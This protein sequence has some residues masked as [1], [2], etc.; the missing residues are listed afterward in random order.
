M[1]VQVRVRRPFSG[2]PARGRPAQNG[3][4]LEGTR[5]RHG[6]AAPAS[7]TS[8]GGSSPP[9]ATRG[10]SAFRGGSGAGGRCAGRCTTWPP[11]AR[12]P[13]SSSM[14]WP[15]SHRGRCPARPCRP[16]RPVLRRVRRC[17]ARRWWG[18]PIWGGGPTRCS[19]RHCSGCIRAVPT[20]PAAPR[21]ASTTTT[22]PTGPPPTSPCSTCWIVSAATATPSRPGTTGHWSRAG[23]N[24]HWYGRR[25]LV[26]PRTGLGNRLARRRPA[27][28]VPRTFAMS[29][30]AGRYD[31][32]PP[33]AR[34]GPS[35]ALR[36]L[37]PEPARRRGPMSP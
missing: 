20:R 4:C 1:A 37:S 17:G 33:P 12:P 8:R 28:D 23:A 29:A 36:L 6:R 25:I 7:A 22:G 26:I 14:R 32:R 24:G 15:G 3:A 16:A 27:A 35:D 10:T 34:A 31:P 18:W 19:R 2:E 21:P 13:C 11:P 5:H 30:A 9:V